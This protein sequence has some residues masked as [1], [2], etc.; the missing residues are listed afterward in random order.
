M[1][2]MFKTVRQPVGLSVATRLGEGR[3]MRSTTPPSVLPILLDRPPRVTRMIVTG[4]SVM[5]P[6]ASKPNV[7][8]RPRV[9]PRGEE[10][11]EDG[12]AG[13]VGA[14]DGVE[15]RPGRLGGV[16]GGRLDLA[17]GLRLGEAAHEVR[18]RGRKSF[19]D[20]AGE[21]DVHAARRRSG[22]A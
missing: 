21:A 14:A 13:A 3:T 8:S 11:L 17:A 10:L 1:I 7:P 19:R 4:D 12:V 22:A 6:F 9:R 20:R 16:D 18:A 5:S 15:E 2:G